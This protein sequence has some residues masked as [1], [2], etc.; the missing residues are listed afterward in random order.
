MYKWY[1]P[2]KYEEFLRFSTKICINGIVCR[3]KNLCRLVFEWNPLA[4][5]FLKVL[6]DT[7]KKLHIYGSWVQQRSLM[8]M[9]AKRYLQ[10]CPN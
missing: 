1:V 4:I 9:N 3:I 5:L 6:L 2:L 8:N 10:L 7:P